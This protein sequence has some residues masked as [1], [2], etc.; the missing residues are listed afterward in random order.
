MILRSRPCATQAK[1]A[2]LLWVHKLFSAEDCPKEQH[3][4]GPGLSEQVLYVTFN[5]GDSERCDQKLRG[6]CTP[7]TRGTVVN[8]QTII[9]LSPCLL[10]IRDL[11]N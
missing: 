5:A 9:D 2:S 11:S 10:Y 1:C 7:K 8:S 6:I 4:K 3:V